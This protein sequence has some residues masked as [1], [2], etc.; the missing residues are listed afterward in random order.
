[1][2]CPYRLV[3]TGITAVLSI[4]WIRKATAVPT[5]AEGDQPLKMKSCD[6]G[7]ACAQ[8]E[9]SSGCP[10]HK[11]TPRTVFL[12]VFLVLLHVDFLFTGYLHSGAKEL[13]AHFWAKG[14]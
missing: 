4:L 3:T 5:A 11:W 8:T 7:S 13:I 9:G 6:G 10:L 1:M 12:V 2:V 14:R